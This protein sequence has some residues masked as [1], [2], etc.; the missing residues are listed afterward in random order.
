MGF[1][2]KLKNDF[3]KGINES[4]SSVTSVSREI[5]H[6]AD[7]LVAEG[8]KQLE[9]YNMKKKMTCNFSD[10]GER[11]YE[12]MTGDGSNV[13]D[14]EIARSIVETISAIKSQLTEQERERKA[15][16]IKEQDSGETSPETEST[17][18]AQA[19]DS[20]T[21]TA[22]LPGVL[23]A[24]QRR[25]YTRKEKPA[26]Q[27]KRN[28][29]SVRVKNTKATG[30]PETPVTTAAT[31]SAAEDNQTKEKEEEKHEVTGEK[32]A[33]QEFTGEADTSE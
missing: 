23:P 21:E 27:E 32:V 20:E 6:K 1:W 33:G 31:E 19:E 9:L 25:Q 30:T 8:K 4:L 2:D 14:D 22:P 5:G 12:L 24:K 15:E 26:K 11:V 17:T 18:V 7:S 10:L 13:N 3:Q 29:A 28:T 16:T